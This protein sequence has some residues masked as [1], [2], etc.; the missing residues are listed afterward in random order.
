MSKRE[1]TFGSGKLGF[2]AQGSDEGI[3]IIH[4]T[5][6]SQAY[7]QGL[8][9]GDIING[10]NGTPF[11]ES[12]HDPKN[13]EEFAK[14]VGG[15]PRPITLEI[16]SAKENPTFK[17]NEEGIQLSAGQMYRREIWGKAGT[18]SEYYP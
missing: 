1:V 3:R 18:P 15:L 16:I 11:T 17:I 6:D 5:K 4:L 13:S 10:V 2:I 9:V 12:M 7:N 8:Q 14:L